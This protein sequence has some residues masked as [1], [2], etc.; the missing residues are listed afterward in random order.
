MSEAHPRG[1]SCL[2]S[3][4]LGCERQTWTYR[5]CDIV[6]DEAESQWPPSGTPS[7]ESQKENDLVLKLDLHQKPLDPWRG[8]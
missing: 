1:C 8:S 6:T 3:S 4:G 5:E 7:Q 2:L